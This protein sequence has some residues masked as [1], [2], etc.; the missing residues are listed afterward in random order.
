MGTRFAI[1][2]LVISLS[3]FSPA[4]ANDSTARVGTGGIVFLK[5]DDVR[6]LSEKLTISPIQIDVQYHFLNEGGAPI[7]TTVAFPMPLFRWDPDQSDDY[8]NI[9]PVESFKVS[10]DGHI[11]ATKV[12]QKALLG[13]RDITSELRKAHLSDEQIFRTFGDSNSFGGIE[14]PG[15]QAKRLGRLGALSGNLPSWSVSE[16]VYWQ[17]TFPRNREIVV[18]HSYK[19]FRGRA[20]SVFSPAEQ[21]YNP[22]NIPVSSVWGERVDRACLDEGARG[23]IAKRTK[24]LV[25]QGAKQV[26]VLLND[27]EYILGTGRNWKGPIAD[28]TLDIVKETPDQIISL[29]FPGKAERVNDKTVRF[30]RSNFVPPD[31]LLVNFYSISA[32]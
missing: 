22:E 4:Q 7:A 24:Q 16:V 32:D 26:Y 21:S 12:E 23:A 2:F 17:Q 1:V 18:D 13:D 20:Y 11:A 10:V 30:K 3:A 5:N 14:L 28:F 9:G 6:M 15:E 29:C 8:K 19:P 25:Q 27:V 31:R